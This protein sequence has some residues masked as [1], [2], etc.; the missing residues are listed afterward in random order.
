MFV[1]RLPFFYVRK[2]CCYGKKNVYLYFLQPLSKNCV[3]F[4]D[5]R[6]HHFLYGMCLK[7]GSEFIIL[8]LGRL[9]LQTFVN[10]IILHEMSKKNFHASFQGGDKNREKPFAVERCGISGKEEIY[11][12]LERRLLCPASW[13]RLSSTADQI[14][15]NYFRIGV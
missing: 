2:P 3:T 15:L 10:W 9:Q 8:D 11:Q 4:A 7:H 12:D 1:L 13:L 6:N 14:Q 5:L